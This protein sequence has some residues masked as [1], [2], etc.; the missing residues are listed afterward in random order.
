MYAAFQFTFSGT[1]DLLKSAEL[2]S[3]PRHSKYFCPISKLLWLEL[4]NHIKIF[5]FSNTHWLNYFEGFWNWV[6]IMSVKLTTEKL[7]SKLSVPYRT[8]LKIKKPTQ[9]FKKWRKYG[10]QQHLEKLWVYFATR[11][12]HWHCHHINNFWSQSALTFFL[13]LWS[14]KTD[15]QLSQNR[16]TFGD[17]E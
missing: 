8:L 15:L 5:T 10:I 7:L 17:E 11:N 6:Q 3:E 14:K 2:V 16:R 4:T 12:L 13:S 9:S 1:M